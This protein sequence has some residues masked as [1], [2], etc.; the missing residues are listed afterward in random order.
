M[1]AQVNG[2]PLSNDRLESANLV[3]KYVKGVVGTDSRGV[4]DA[5]TKSEAPLLGLSNIRSALQG[6]QLK[7]QLEDGGANLIWLSL[8]CQ[9]L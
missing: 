2:C 8:N 9:P 4:F 1:W 7:E 5:A 6:Y 3:M